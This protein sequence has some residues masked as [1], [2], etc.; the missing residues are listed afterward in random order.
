MSN[1]HE[2]FW[3]DRQY[4]RESAS[5]GVSRYGAYIRQ[6][7]PAFASCWDGDLAG[8][9]ER[10]AAAAW[11]IANGPVMS[12]GYVR[13]H[14]R[15]LAA[16]VRI[17]SWDGTLTGAVDVAAP[18][19]AALA[20]TRDWQGGSRWGDWEREPVIGEAPYWRGPWE[21]EAQ[22]PHLLARITL[23][24]PLGIPPGTIP[25]PHDAHHG[26]L[27][28]ARAAVE[29]LVRAMNTVVTPVI[30]ALEPDG[31]PGSGGD[32]S[33]ASSPAWPRSSAKV[34]GTGKPPDDGTVTAL[35]RAVLQL[36]DLGGMP[37]TIWQTDSR[38]RLARGVLGIPGDGRHTHAHLWET[39]GE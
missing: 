34:T 6:N 33:P 35:A 24:F 7:A 4:D 26:V 36:A 29:V 32:Q 18:W 16:D 8:R 15:I 12:P 13:S 20:G 37:G 17:S 30:A 25:V 10:F 9:A 22:A 21:D 3:I 14:G 23:A 1:G 31:S 19:P 5:D 39:S 28:A 27:Q 2:A 38:V 11:E